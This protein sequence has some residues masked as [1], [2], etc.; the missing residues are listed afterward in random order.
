MLNK[1]FYSIS[2][3]GIGNI[4]NAV[5]GFVFLSAVAKT[6]PVET[7]G[8]YALITSVLVAISKIMDFG[9]N[10]IFVSQSITREDNIKN[11]FLTLRLMLF[12]ITLPIAL[13]VLYVLDVYTLQTAIVFFLGL[14]GYGINNTLFAFFQK[15]QKFNFTYLI[16]T[17]PA[18]IK[19][20]FG[21][22]ALMGIINLSFEYA[23]AIFSIS[24]LSSIIFYNYLPE[25]LKG[26]KFSTKKTFTLLKESTAAGTSLMI[27]VSW[28]ALSN[29][30]LKLAKTFTDVGIFSLAN[31]I[32]N[33]FSL[34]SLSIFTVLLPKNAARKKDAQGYDFKETGVIAV[35]VLVLAFFA[36]LVGNAFI[37]I[38]FGDKFADSLGVLNILI[39]AYAI[40]AIHTFLNN[41][42][43]IEENTK[44]ILLITGVHLGS[45]LILGF[46]LIPQYSI[47]GLGYTHLISTTIA[48]GTSIY[49]IL[50]NKKRT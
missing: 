24:M 17:I 16:N 36:I 49:A 34:V 37:N 22:L 30:I 46:L 8:K 13:F 5:L 26:F 9:T 39:I 35:G 40:S 2:F 7:F 23:Y 32:A 45:F 28:G 21:F 41:Y 15:A 47:I 44:V 48:L 14:V 38:V 19:T 20:V 3:V 12:V 1:S 42:F 11:E 10:S 29:S 50:V 27:G 31:R 33:I 18:A 6:L 43:F 25:E 4:L